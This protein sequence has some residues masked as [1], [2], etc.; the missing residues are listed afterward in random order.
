MADPNP[1]AH[2]SS[3]EAAARLGAAEGP[4]VVGAQLARHGGDGL[5]RSVPVLVHAPVLAAQG[6]YRRSAQGSGPEVTVQL[7]QE[8]PMRGVGGTRRRAASAT[9]DALDAALVAARAEAARRAAL[10]FIATVEAA[11]LLA[12]RDRALDDAMRLAQLSRRRVEVGAAQPLEGALGESERG[13]ARAAHIEA[14]GV[15]IE[16]SAE[17]AIA[18]GRDLA[19]PPATPITFAAPAKPVVVTSA[20]L[21]RLVELNP[22]VRALDERA[23]AAVA[24]VG[25]VRAVGGATVVAGA[26]YQREGNGDQ[27]GVGQ[28]AVG[29]PFFDPAAFDTA[30]RR[31]EAAALQASAQIAR[32]DARKELYLARHDTEHYLELFEE[33]GTGAVG[34]ARETVRLAERAWSAGTETLAQLLFA[35]QR[36]V[37]AEEQL[38]HARAELERAHV[39][40]DYA[41]GRLAESP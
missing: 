33:V 31:V 16:A 26:S 17:L 1:S 19:T 9:R 29:L 12:L 3:V 23:R 28:L 38:L 13:R 34:P 20:E 41:A 35:R 7:S 37:G 2:L 40:F 8:I 22:T 24:Q 30:E 4:A 25:V 27:V 5:G 10:A 39:R 21:A 11:A 14:E 18:T 36:L 32:A 15:L 6:G